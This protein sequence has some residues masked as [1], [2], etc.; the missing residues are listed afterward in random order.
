MLR[1]WPVAGGANRTRLELAPRRE[2]LEF[3]LGC[4]RVDVLH[5]DPRTVVKVLC[6]MGQKR[7]PI[8]AATQQ[9]TS[10]RIADPLRHG[11]P[12]LAHAGLFNFS[13]AAQQEAEGQRVE[14]A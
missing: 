12:L 10:L 13:D 7:A 11:E 4:H 2:A 5:P 14:V 6:E 3:S 9:A 1:H 8:A